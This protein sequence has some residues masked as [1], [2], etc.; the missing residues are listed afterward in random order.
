MA[1]LNLPSGS[2]LSQR[3][4]R[5]LTMWGAKIPAAQLD[6]DEEFGDLTRQEFSQLRMRLK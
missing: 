5:V 6:G 2:P 1:Q 4:L 3:Y